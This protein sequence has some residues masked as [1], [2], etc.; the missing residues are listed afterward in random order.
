ME[1]ERKPTHTDRLSRVNSLLHSLSN[2]VKE[3][4]RLG[5]I[6]HD[7]GD[8]LLGIGVVD[9]AREVCRDGVGKAVWL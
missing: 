1:A 4:L 7:G 2:P 9:E 5:E 3:G 8:E 6:S